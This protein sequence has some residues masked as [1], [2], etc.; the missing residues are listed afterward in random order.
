MP[1]KPKPDQKERLAAIANVRDKIWDLIALGTNAKA[2]FTSVA[3]GRYGVGTVTYKL[4][5][6]LT[7]DR[8]FEKKILAASAGKGAAFMIEQ[9]AKRG[10]ADFFADDDMPP[11]PRANGTGTFMDL[12][13]ATEGNSHHGE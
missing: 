13:K 6:D 12:I 1:T 9:F 11:P 3:G 8:E 10:L 7:F 5:I 2:K 4:S